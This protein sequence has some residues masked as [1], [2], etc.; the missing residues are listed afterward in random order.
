MRCVNA[1]LIVCVVIAIAGCGSNRVPVEG[2]ITLDGK[3]LGGVHVMFFPMQAGGTNATLYRAVSDDQGHF[4]LESPADGGAGVMPGVYR[5]TLS[6]AVAGPN[7]KETTPLPP[8]RAG[9]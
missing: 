8:E 3:P 2:A 7:D 1:R 5:V 9:A 6:T 4:A